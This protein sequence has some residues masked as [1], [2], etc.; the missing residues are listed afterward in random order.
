METVEIAGIRIPSYRK[1]INSTSPVK[2]IETETT[3]RNLQ[4]ILYPLLEGKPVLLIG[5]AGVGK[6]ALV[7]HINSLRN[8]PTIRFSFNEDTLPEDLIGSYRIHPSG[9]GFEWKNG[10]LTSALQTG[11]AF[12][13]DEMNL[14]SPS[15]IKRFSTVYESFYLDL[16]EG[17]GE[18]IS[19]V[20]GF[21]FIATQNPSEGFEGRKNLSYEITKNFSVVYIDSYPPE[22]IYQI[23][24]N[25]YPELLESVIKNIINVNFETENRVL[26]GELGRNDLEKY[27]FNLR[28][29][30]RLSAR[31]L[32]YNCNDTDILYQ[33]FREIY[34]DCFRNAEDRAKQTE[35]VSSV[36]SYKSDRKISR[37]EIFSDAEYIYCND[38]RIRIKNPE[39]TKEI[40]SAV[41]MT[42]SLRGF[43]EKVFT[44][45]EMGENI[46][47]EYSEEDD[48]SI[49]MNL[50]AD[51]SGMKTEFIH[52]CK[53][54][55]TSDIIGAL[56]PVSDAGQENTGRVEWVD[57][58]LSRG[59]EE[60]SH[61]MITSLETAGAELVEKFNMLTD[62]A[63]ALLLPAESGKKEELHLSPEAR[64]YAFKVFRKTKSVSTI[65]RAFRNRFTSVL[66]PQLNNEECVYDILKFYLPESSL[67]NLMR[68]FH[69][70]IRTMAEKRTI[71]SANLNP[72]IFG[73]PNLLSWIRH[74]LHFNSENLE[75]TVFRGAGVAYINQIYDAKE[76]NE[77]E[78]LLKKGWDLGKIPQG[79]FQE[80][81]SKK[82]TFTESSEID[83]NKWWNPE[84]SKRDPNTGKAELKMSGEKLKAGIDI[85]T[86]ETGGTTKEGADAWYGSET[87]GNMG[88]G[89]PAGG[90]G[91]W[92]YRTEELYKQFLAKRK[93]LW[94]YSMPVS[95]KEFW[96]IFGKELEETR[97]NLEKLFDPE[98]DII[99]SYRN[100][101]NRIDAR[102]YIGYLSGKGDTKVFDKTI[103]DKKEEK[104][105]GVEVVFLVSKSRRIF[106]FE[107]AIVV[108]S[109]IITSS[110]VL[111][112]HDVPF[113]IYAYS[114]RMNKKD[115]IDLVHLKT[116]HESYDEKEE[117]IFKSLASDWQ[118]DSVHEYLLLEDIEKYFTPGSTTRVLVMVSDFR[119]Q[120]GKASI[121]AEIGSFENRKL[122][123]QIL[124]VTNKSYVLLGV[125]MGAR[126]IAE[127]LFF[128]SIQITPDNF[129]SMPN[130][131][132]SAISNLILVNHRV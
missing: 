63:R 19:S 90:G 16:L 96:E 13:A 69:M 21:H 102:K 18:K 60:G 20:D 110:I 77:L 115:T 35:L 130:L 31:L 98:I 45:H 89:E 14:A 82:K 106:N 101:G 61:I 124:R 105:K 79:L 95:K 9:K 57:G 4:K 83:K 117:E 33:H 28:T 71:G 1:R 103:L 99:R 58:P 68:E 92:G 2:I 29:M 107:Y 10:P 50:L 37:V 32:N 11:S 97:M 88:Q 126:Y 84:L 76:R 15:V 6:N 53:G 42:A 70:K 34:V 43:L 127:E 131:L 132:G 54:I 17:G 94:D 44:C 72:Y 52:L 62:D 111:N 85:N 113:S 55:H 51:F 91:A 125:G 48:P 38:K 59:I 75:E 128:N 5:D 73:I 26:R 25:L 74:I 41:P 67:L 80:I 120:R 109:A 46:L 66:F 123:E 47:I 81:E 56:K 23:L 27:H 39:R 12:V 40:L 49:V 36:L 114:D 65:S 78:K 30:K 100:E 112:G 3:K 104:L 24:K 108:L 119:G 87:R 22:E 86:P 64:V 121:D 122:K 8:L 116:F 129:S 93:I 7:Y 118:G